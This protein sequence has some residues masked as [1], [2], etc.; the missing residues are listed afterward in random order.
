[1]VASSKTNMTPSRKEPPAKY[2]VLNSLLLRAR[3]AGRT[4]RDRME[5]AKETSSACYAGSPLSYELRFFCK[6]YCK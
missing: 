3:C 4:G 6:K 5:T 1:M 2:L